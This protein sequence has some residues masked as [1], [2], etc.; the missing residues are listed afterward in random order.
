MK[1]SFGFADFSRLGPLGPFNLLTNGDFATGDLTGWTDTSTGTGVATVVGEVAILQRDGGGTDRIS[2]AVTTVAS[3]QY[4]LTFD[5]I[6]ASPPTGNACF[7]QIGTA[8]SAQDIHGTT[9]GYGSQSVNFTATT[10][11]T[12][13]AFYCS[14]LG[15]ENHV[16]NVFLV[17]S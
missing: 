14:G 8:Q 4:T 1:L 15:N 3:Q 7:L 16:D 2:Q 6:D 13:I 5:I 12:H 11:T 17:K 9:Y 10:T